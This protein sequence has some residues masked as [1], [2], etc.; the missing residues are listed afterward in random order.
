MDRWTFFKKKQFT[1]FQSVY[2]SLSVHRH[3]VSPAFTT[4][5]FPNCLCRLQGAFLQE[6]VSI[7]RNTIV[8][9]DIKIYCSNVK[10]CVFSK[11]CVPR[12]RYIS[13]HNSGTNGFH[14]FTAAQ[15]NINIPI[16]GIILVFIKCRICRFQWVTFVN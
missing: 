10:H 13:F 6:C 3:N 2:S 16:S 4:T 15:L 7:L 12:Q 1:S 8:Y 14:F 9:G 11:S 5:V